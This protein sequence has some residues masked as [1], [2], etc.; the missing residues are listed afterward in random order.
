MRASIRLKADVEFGAAA[1]LTGTS[2]LSNLLTVSVW[3]GW[4]CAFTPSIVDFILPDMSSILTVPATVGFG[5]GLYVDFARLTFHVPIHGS[6]DWALTGALTVTR[7]ANATKMTI[8]FCIAHLVG[9]IAR[10]HRD[11][12]DPARIELVIHPSSPM[13]P[14]FLRRAC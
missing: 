14:S 10:P 8:R 6:A 3:V 7:V 13:E 12:C 2:V 11:C 1:P 4:P 5:P 9:Q